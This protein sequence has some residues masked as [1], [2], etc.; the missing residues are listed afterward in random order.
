MCGRFTQTAKPD[1]LAATFAQAARMTG[2]AGFKRFNVAPTDEVLAIVSD[3]ARR[4]MDRLRWGLVPF[5]SDDAKGAAKMINAR[6]ETLAKTPAYR[7]LVPE[8]ASR[9]LVIADG[10]YEW[11]RAED[12][13]SPR[14]PVHFTLAERRPFAF[15]GLWTTWRPPDGGERLKTCTIV[16]CPANSVVAPVHSR[17]PVMLCDE[18]RRD[19]WLDP[20]LDA[21][22]V[23]PLMVTLDS[24]P[25]L[26][27]RV[28][29]AANTVR[30]DGPECLE[31]PNPQPEQSRLC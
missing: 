14:L 28:S 19:A 27:R 17:M 31:D 25:L 18:A 12:P 20:S 4:R 7:A 6:A 16:T 15:A 23:A 8:A 9:C 29:A 24:E 30:N 13:K 10:F 5:W 2:S 1:Q 11:M 26:A 21:A 3:D 22:G